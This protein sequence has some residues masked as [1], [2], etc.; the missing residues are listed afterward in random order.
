MEKFLIFMF[1]DCLCE[2][3]M[4]VYEWFDKFNF[5][6]VLFFVVFEFLILFFVEFIVGFGLFLD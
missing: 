3:K 4:L 6:E 1:C 5:M 2:V